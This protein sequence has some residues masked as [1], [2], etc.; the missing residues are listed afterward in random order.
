MQNKGADR[1]SP[2]RLSAAS[3]ICGGESPRFGVDGMRYLL[4]ILLLACCSESVVE[5][6]ERVMAELQC[7]WHAR[8][9]VCLCLIDRQVVGYKGFGYMT[10]VPDRVCELRVK[11]E[12]RRGQTASRAK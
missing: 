4:L 8:Y 3:L 9:Q 10:W 1:L 5:E 7:R 12:P 6:R 2:R 11:V